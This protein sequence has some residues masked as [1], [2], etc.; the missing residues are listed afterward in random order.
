MRRPEREYAGLG[1]AGGAPGSDILDAVVERVADQVNQ[2]VADLLQHR[3]VELGVLAVQFQ[4][5]LLAELRRQIVDQPREAVEADAD[6]AHAD[7]HDAFLQLARVAGELVEAR[8]QSLPREVV[9]VGAG[10]V[11]HGLRDDQFADLV[12]EGV[13]LVDA[14][15]DGA[16]L[17]HHRSGARRARGGGRRGVP[18]RAGQYLVAAGERR[19]LQLAL[20]LHPGKDFL[21]LRARHVA[22]QRQPPAEVDLLGVEQARRR[23]SLDVGLYHQVAETLELAEHP[24]RLVATAQHVWRRH[25]LDTPGRCRFRC[26]RRAGGVCRRR[27]AEQFR[28]RRLHRGDPPGVGRLATLQTMQHVAQTIDRLERQAHGVRGDRSAGLADIV[29]QGLQQVREVT[30]QPEAESTAAALD[31]VRGTKDGVHRLAVGGA[32]LEREQSGLHGVQALGA[33]LEE[34][35]MELCD[36]YRHAGRLPPL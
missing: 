22:V 14:D 36:V 3:A 24:Q 32:R 18:G 30:H 16:A 21:D 34:D 17:G 35:L 15:T 7:L 10:L 1:L 25:E 28:E 9:G 8:A 12:D 33:L 6:R 13:D 20:V 29:E 5:D 26:H 27:L 19:D 2:R 4:L 23:H 31:G 11:E